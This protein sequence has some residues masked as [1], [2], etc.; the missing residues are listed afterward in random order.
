MIGRI[1]EHQRR[2]VV[3]VKR[4]VGELGLEVDGLVRAVLFV[5]AQDLADVVVTAGED[6]TVG[7]ASRPRQIPQFA[8]GR[9]RVMEESFIDRA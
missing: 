3:L 6:G 7:L 2:R 9:V 1:V 4:S 5:I 8:I